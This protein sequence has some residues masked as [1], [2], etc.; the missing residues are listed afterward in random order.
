MFSDQMNSSKPLKETAHRIEI[1]MAK[2]TNQQYKNAQPG[3]DHSIKEMRVRQKIC[4]QALKIII[5]RQRK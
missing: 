5:A 2:N 4:E 3:I 1:K